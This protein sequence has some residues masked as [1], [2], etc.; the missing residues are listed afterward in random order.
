MVDILF[1]TYFI[2]LSIDSVNSFSNSCFAIHKKAN[3]NIINTNDLLIPGIKST[4]GSEGAGYQLSEAQPKNDSRPYL[5]YILFATLL[6]AD[7]ENFKLLGDTFGFDSQ[8]KVSLFLIARWS[9]LS[10]CN[11]LFA[12][13]L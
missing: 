5:Q 6:G 7:A 9:Y 4:A 3:G 13:K 12:P 8:V 11:Y 1:C 2:Q 10:G